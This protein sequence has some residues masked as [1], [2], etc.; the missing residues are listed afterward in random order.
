MAEFDFLAAIDTLSHISGISACE[1][2]TA[3]F[4]ESEF[5]RY[6]DDVNI[7]RMGN[8]IATFRGTKCDAKTILIDSHSDEIGFLVCDYAEGGFVKLARVGGMDPGVLPATELLIHAPSGVIRGVV[9]AKPPH[10]MSEA[11]R[12]KKAKLEDLYLDT[13][14]SEEACKAQIPLGTPVGFASG[15]QKLLNARIAARGLDDR[16]AGLCLLSLAKHLAEHPPVHNVI[17]LCSVQEEVGGVGAQTAAFALSPDV[18]LCVDVSFADFPGST[19]RLLELG[20]GV[21]ISYSDTLSRTLTEE[22]VRLAK[23]QEIPYQLLAEAG[24]TG[25]NAHEIQVAGRGVPSTIL[26]LPLSYMHSPSEVVD[27]SDLVSA[28]RLMD[29]YCRTGTFF[30]EEVTIVGR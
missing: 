4:F 3:A 15:A 2:E 24:E 28:V 30:A 11:D 27:T 13:L 26:S 8:V 22:V 9:A 5:K 10:L 23:A 16:V 6:C 20:G 19:G 7:D 14:L 1:Q 18:C 12:K 17:L 25:T 21:G 29:A